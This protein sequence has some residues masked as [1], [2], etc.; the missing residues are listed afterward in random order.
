M[1]RILINQTAP[2]NHI[3]FRHFI[4][5]LPRFSHKP[6]TAIP[7]RM[8]FHETTS[9]WDVLSNTSKET[10]REPNQI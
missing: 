5:Y 7:A 9:H 3:S 4:K 2:R 1:F 10:D 8:L 6:R